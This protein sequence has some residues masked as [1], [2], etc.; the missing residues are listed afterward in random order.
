MY[1]AN[2]SILWFWL[3]LG[4]CWTVFYFTLREVLSPENFATTQLTVSR[5]SLIVVLVVVAFT[6]YKRLPPILIN[7]PIQ[8][9]IGIVRIVFFAILGV[10]SLV[11]PTFRIEHVAF[12]E[13]TSPQLS[14]S[15]FIALVTPN[16]VNIALWVM[17]IAGILAMVG[18]QTRKSILVFALAAFYVFTAQNLYGKINHS[19]HIFWFPLLML[20]TNA[21]RYYSLDEW[22]KKR[23]GI[24]EPIKGDYGLVNLWLTLGIM[25]FF[26]GFWKVW[27]IGLDWVFT[28]NITHQLYLKWYA[29]DWIPIFRI[30]QYPF[31][32]QFGALFTVLFELAFITLLF[33][34][35]SRWLAVISGIVFHLSTLVF[36]KIFFYFLPMV[37]ITLIRIRPPSTDQSI[38]WKT[39]KMKVYAGLFVVFFSGNILTGFLHH[40]GLFFTCYPTFSYALPQTQPVLFIT[41]NDEPVAISELRKYYPKERFQYWEYEVINNY[42]NGNLEQ[43]QK[44]LNALIQPFLNDLSAKDTLRVYRVEKSLQPEMTNPQDLEKAVLLLQWSDTTQH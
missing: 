31:L 18:W 34:K 9:W 32:L 29:E 35:R 37:Y 4:I 38:S 3:A 39:K 1:R 6:L 23:Q 7:P 24:T 11:H 5:I 16:A 2:S 40:D 8:P 44:K 26:P 33:D 27:R 36:L 28:D 10:G 21:H 15:I 20:F 43:S 14:D 12:F 42:D 41:V 30:D 19:H 22:L 25:Y 17:S 13:Q